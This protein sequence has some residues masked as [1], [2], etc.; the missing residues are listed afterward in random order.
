MCQQYHYQKPD[1]FLKLLD[2]QPR[3]QVIKVWLTDVEKSITLRFYK[4]IKKVYG[5]EFYLR[6]NLM[7]RELLKLDSSKVFLV[8]Y[9]CSILIYNIPTGNGAKTT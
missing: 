6:W 4:Q 5:E 8:S 7:Q 2:S 3:D 1:D 9:L